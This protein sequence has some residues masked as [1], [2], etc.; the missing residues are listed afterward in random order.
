[1]WQGRWCTSAAGAWG[2]GGYIA[3]GQLRVVVDGDGG[4]SGL[5]LHLLLLQRIN[6]TRA[7]GGRG[8]DLIVMNKM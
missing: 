8:F 2:G 4:G 6:L 3:E 1:M 7:G 5:L